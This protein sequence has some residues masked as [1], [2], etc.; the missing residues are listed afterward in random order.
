MLNHKTVEKKASSPMVHSDSN[1][2]DASNIK[3]SLKRTSLVDTVSHQINLN[4][5]KL[6]RET[7][8]C[9]VYYD[10]IPFIHFLYRLLM[11]QQVEG[12]CVL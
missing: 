6:N 3:I 11:A 5:K 8:F 10:I 4:N 2:R 9:A 7:F 12:V 1:N